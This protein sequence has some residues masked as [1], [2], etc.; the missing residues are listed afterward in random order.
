MRCYEFKYKEN[1]REKKEYVKLMEGMA[2]VIEVDKK[3][4]FLSLTSSIMARPRFPFMN[5]SSR[6]AFEWKWR[7]IPRGDILCF[8]LDGL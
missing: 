4:Y 5:N 8:S 1:I 7:K 6:R 3:F 2:P